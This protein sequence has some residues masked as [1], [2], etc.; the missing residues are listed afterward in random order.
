VIIVAG[1]L[2][3]LVIPGW[4]FLQ[5]IS[6]NVQ[7]AKASFDAGTLT[8][9]PPSEKVKGWPI[10]GTKLFETWQSASANLRDTVVKYKT[11]LVGIGS[12][13][14][15][16]I[17]SFGAGIIQLVIALFI[18]GALLA[19]AG[20]GDAVRRIFTKLAGDRGDEL[21]DVIQKTVGKV[22]KGVLGV[23]LIQSILIGTG[24]LLSGVPYAGIL[25]LAIF[26]LAVVQIPTM[27]I[28]LPAVIY[29]F[30]VKSTAVAVL[31]TV[32]LM[33]GG[34]S[35]N[36]LKPILLGKGAPV[37]MLVIFVGVIG[38]FILSGLI[39]LFTGAIVMSVGYKLFQAWLSTSAPSVEFTAETQ[40]AQ[41]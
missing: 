11:E 19:T 7:D 40:R 29:L 23:A 32:F 21:A 9:P 3:L 33:V 20:T 14:G 2:V 22:V 1:C 10:V 16:G 13:V 5:A 26:L 27:L 24:L 34:L 8:I 4:L 37:P 35:D 17:L 30:S 38:G 12:I 18:A 15:K 28:V 25:A 31:W 39:G 41:S 6:R 36:V